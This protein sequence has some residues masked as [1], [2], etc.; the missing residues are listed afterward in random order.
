MSSVT[1]GRPPCMTNVA[2]RPHLD[3]R[4]SSDGAAPTPWAVAEEALQGAELFWLTTVRPDGRPHAT[5]LIAVWND[6]ALWFCT[7][8]EERKARN[9][10]RHA[11]CLLLTGQNS[12]HAGLDLVVEGEAE[13]V[14]D[15]AALRPVAEAYLAKYGTDWRFDVVDGAFLHA[16]ESLRD[17]DPGKALV[18]RVSPRTVFGYGKGE[19]YSQTRWSFGR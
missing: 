3:A 10:E 7:G 12:L 2:P 1:G 4:F 19:P 15:E 13:Q 16:R 18:F 9:L 17:A 8:P 5:P 14:S 11:S 6:G